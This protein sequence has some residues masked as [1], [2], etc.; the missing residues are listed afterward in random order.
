MNKIMIAHIAAATAALSAGIAVV[1]TRFVIVETDPA[2]LAFYR[3]VI[4]VMCFVPLFPFIWPK[5]RIELRE[6]GKIALFGTLFFCL[7]PWAFN[8]SLQYIP[9]ARGA[10]GLATIPIQTLI[11]AAILGREVL[12]PAKLAGVAL[13]FVGISVVFGPEAISTTSSDYLI[14]DG[15]MI[16]GGFCAALYS[17]LNRATLALHGPLFVTALAMVFGALAL[18]PLTLLETGPIS[19]PSFSAEG[20]LAVIF[21]GT[22]AGAIQFS[23]FTWALR[24]LPPTVTVLYLTLNPITAMMLGMLLIGETVSVPLVAGLVLVIGGIIVANGLVSG[25]LRKATP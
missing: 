6:Y 3:Y 15:L 19:F 2:A 13:A 7:F 18:Y 10:V 11:V 1:A 16:L 25:L 4:G 24:W 21:L 22:L 5:H 9:A 8:A 12:T 17:V 23:L 20:W 14:G